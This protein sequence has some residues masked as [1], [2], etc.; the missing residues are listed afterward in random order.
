MD[1]LNTDRVSWG[2]RPWWTGDASG[3]FWNGPEMEHCEWR[4]E[5]IPQDGVDVTPKSRPPKFAARR[6]VERVWGSKLPMPM[7]NKPQLKTAKFMER[8]HDELLNPSN[9]CPLIPWTK[10]KTKDEKIS[11]WLK[12]WLPKSLNTRFS[13]VHLIF[14]VFTEIDLTRGLKEPPMHSFTHSLITHKQ[15]PLG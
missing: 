13:S 5:R 11:Y 15:C 14:L 1:W 6:G 12:S 2:C 10:V 8:L 9:L 4:R 3:V 7:P